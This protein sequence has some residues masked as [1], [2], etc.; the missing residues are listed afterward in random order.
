MKFDTPKNINYAATVVALK[1]FVDLQN[2]DNVKAALIFGS[3]VIVGKNTLVGDVGLFFPAECQLSP[4]FLANNNLYRKAEFGNI[5]PNQKGFFEQH[6]RVKAMKFRG[7]KSEGFWIPL[8]SLLYLN[9]PLAEFNVGDV[10]DYVGEHEICRK[11]IVKTNSVSQT[12]Q[13][14]KVARLEDSIVDG[15]FRFHYDTENLR[16]NIHKIY[17][18][19]YISISDKWHGTSIVISNVLVKRNLNW[20]E[21]ILKSLKVNISDQV[22]GL[23]YSSRRVVKSVNGINKSNNIHYYDEDIWGVVAKEVEDR[24]PKGYTLYGEI[25]GYTPTG[26]MIQG[27]YHYGCGPGQHKFIIYRVTNTNSDGK[28]L[29]LT[30]AQMKEFCEKYNFGMVKELYYG[31]AIDFY[32]M[33]KRLRDLY[34]ESKDLAVPQWQEKFLKKLEETYIQDAMCPYNNNEVLQEGIVLRIDH[35]EECSA[36]K[37]KNFAFLEAE[38]K[39]N[40]AGVIDIETVE[41]EN[42]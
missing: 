15:Q 32:P 18:Y 11:Y 8:T 23:T 19:D 33:N 41:S 3:S 13:K 16:R 36:F 39:A 12:R 35:L 14:G 37:L 38:S 22:Y 9:I 1:D 29:E 40:D 26:S 30:W 5:D 6:G 4:E 42:G 28:T 31:R 24:L 34:L 25:V 2:C 20:F 17:P 7:H 21:K 27:G 10:F